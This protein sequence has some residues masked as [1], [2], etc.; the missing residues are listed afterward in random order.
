M[1][2]IGPLTLIE[3]ALAKLDVAILKEAETVA[4][5]LRVCLSKEAKKMRMEEDAWREVHSLITELK[6]IYYYLRVA[7]AGEPAGL[8]NL[9]LAEEKISSTEQKIGTIYRD[10]KSAI[11]LNAAEEKL[12]RNAAEN[13]NKVYQQLRERL[14]ELRSKANT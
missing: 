4:A 1:P 3:K 9:R 6:S 14:E 8:A 10:I 2:V 11:S 5:E 13:L 7:E 12:A